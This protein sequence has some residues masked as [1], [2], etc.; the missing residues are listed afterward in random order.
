MTVSTALEYQRNW[1][2]GRAHSSRRCHHAIVEPLKPCESGPPQV[3]PGT[4]PP[5]A[6]QKPE[7]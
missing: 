6:E 5:C 2:R 1:T 7:L 3:A 4:G